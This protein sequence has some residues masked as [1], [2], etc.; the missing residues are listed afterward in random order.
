MRRIV[1]SRAERA[2]CG[3]TRSLRRVGVRFGSKMNRMPA[4]ATESSMSHG[5][6]L[7]I[8]TMLDP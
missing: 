2:L 7:H 1:A 6:P 4:R 5:N 8:A 3:K